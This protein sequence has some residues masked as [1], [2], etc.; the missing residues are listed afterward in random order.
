M[1]FLCV[2]KLT[3]N[4]KYAKLC[5]IMKVIN[6]S[7]G[8]DGNLTYI[9]TDNTK[10]LVDDGLS[11]K[12]TQARLALLGVDGREIDGIV[13]SHEHS[14]H[15][16]GVD[17]FAK[18]FDIPVYAHDEVWMGLNDKLQRV[19]D[20]NK[21]IFDNAF[22]I[23]DLVINPV[24]VPH[25]VK[26]FGFTISEND[27]KIGVLTDL[28]HTNERI[29]NEFKGCQLVYVEANHDLNMLKNCEKYPLT[30]KLRIAGNNGH[31]SNDA[32]AEFI[33]KLVTT[34]TK[35]V[36]LAHLSRENNSPEFAYNYIT[37]KLANKNLIEGEMFKIDVALTRPTTLFKL[38]K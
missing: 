34:G 12:E 11:C 38:K 3:K 2:I 7:S 26:C 33:E 14:D 22:A 1:P 20:K 16:K 19:S 5:A 29:F 30:L 35:Q 8:S 6:L 17:V 15:I 23:K 21:K 10:I 13:V 4:D 27:K 25:D 36:V 9:E 28:G 32:S 37:S 31:L 24:E 18:K